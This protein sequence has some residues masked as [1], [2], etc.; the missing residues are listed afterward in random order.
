[1][2]HMYIFWNEGPNK[3]ITVVI[4][5]IIHRPDINISSSEAFR[6]CLL[7]SVKGC[8]LKYLQLKG[9]LW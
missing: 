6:F 9:T 5:N 8:F 3:R 1:M 7:L 4:L 2:Y